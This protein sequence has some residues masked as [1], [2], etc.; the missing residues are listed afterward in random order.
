MT[1]NDNLNYFRELRKAKDNKKML[2]FVGAGILKN[3]NLPSRNDL[4]KELA[5]KIKYAPYI[6]NRETYKFSTDK[7]L[8]IS[9]G[10]HYTIKMYGDIEDLLNIVLK[11]N[12]YLNYTSNHILIETFIKSL[13]VD[14]TFIFVGYSLNDYNLKQIM[15]WIDYLSAKQSVSEFKHRNF[16]IQ[17]VSRIYTYSSIQK[18]S[19]GKS[20]LFWR[21]I[22]ILK[23]GIQKLALDKKKDFYIRIHSKWKQAL[24]IY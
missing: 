10:Y 16:I 20:R 18:I 17:N 14:H 22:G 11:E 7:D 8:L 24:S 23:N 19:L 13:L 5:D 15:S 12:D 3:S 21:N 4:V 1:K 9:Q 6:Q 2:F